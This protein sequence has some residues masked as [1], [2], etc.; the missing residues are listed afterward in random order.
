MTEIYAYDSLCDHA[1]DIYLFELSEI[2]H[3]MHYRNQIIA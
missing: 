1:Q 2:S 3:S